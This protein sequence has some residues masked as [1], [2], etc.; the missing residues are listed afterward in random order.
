MAWKTWPDFICGA[1]N[2][3]HFQKVFFWNLSSIE[4]YLVLTGQHW[5]GEHFQNGSFQESQ[6]TCGNLICRA[7]TAWELSSRTAFFG[8]SVCWQLDAGNT[9]IPE[10]T[11]LQASCWAIGWSF[12]G[13]NFICRAPWYPK[14]FRRTF[15]Q[16]LLTVWKPPDPQHAGNRIE[17]HTSGRS[18]FSKSQ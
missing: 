9:A 8:I 14:Q 3:E 4:R 13:L 15:E 11:W 12:E 16:N 7:T 18:S 10:N 2:W 1:T 5:F 17:K 6:E